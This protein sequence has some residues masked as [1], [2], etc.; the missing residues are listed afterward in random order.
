MWLK[1]VQVLGD[2]VSCQANSAAQA[3]PE[4][5]PQA[6]GSLLAKP[7][8][9]WKKSEQRVGGQPVTERP[10]CEMRGRELD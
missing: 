8:L 1:I 6:G 9:N 7:V 5:D 10:G 4:A 3:D 2:D